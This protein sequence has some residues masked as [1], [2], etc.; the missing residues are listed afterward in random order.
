MNQLSNNRTIINV[1]GIPAITYL[2]WYGGVPFTLFILLVM[3]IGI[4]EF[5]QLTTTKDQT[6]LKIFGYLFTFLLA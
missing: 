4:N 5:Y 3:M 6:P 2:L 1:I